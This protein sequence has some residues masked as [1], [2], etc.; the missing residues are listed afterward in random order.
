MRFQHAPEQMP[1]AKDCEQIYDSR[2]AF[3]FDI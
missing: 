2:G 3:E 1:E